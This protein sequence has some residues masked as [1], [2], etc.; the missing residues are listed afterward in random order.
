MKSSVLRHSSNS[1][2]G[3]A[4]VLKSLRIAH[5]TQE[6]SK[7][8]SFTFALSLPLIPCIKYHGST[9]GSQM[10][11]VTLKSK[12]VYSH[13][14]CFQVLTR[15]GKN[16]DAM[17]P[18]LFLGTGFYY[19]ASNR[20]WDIAILYYLAIKYTYKNNEAILSAETKILSYAP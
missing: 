8:L 6:H 13:C 11:S 4:Q 1:R 12:N 14:Q 15:K 9:A 3:E 17:L 20:I 10:S 2:I 19:R 5:A 7:T 18:P 16:T